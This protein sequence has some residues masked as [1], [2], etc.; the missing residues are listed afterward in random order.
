MVLE[1]GH[2]DLTPRQALL[3]L[4]NALLSQSQDANLTLN[5]TILLM[6]RLRILDGNFQI[7]KI[8]YNQLYNAMIIKPMIH[9]F[10]N[11]M[12]QNIYYS[13][14]KIE[15]HFSGDPSRI[16]D[17]SNE[18]QIKSNLMI[19]RGIGMH[20]AEIATTVVKLYQT[21]KKSNAN[22]IKRCAKSCPSLISTLNLEFCLLD[23]VGE[24]G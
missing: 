11:Q 14:L 16:F 15:S 8:S 9:R 3:V 23:K 4:W 10:Y 24:L 12:T 21:G 5:N 17:S 22:S 7:S 6:E 19:F 2:I 20:K 13:I 18:S 1:N